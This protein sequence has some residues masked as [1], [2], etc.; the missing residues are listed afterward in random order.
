MR[1]IYFK[2]IA[3]V[4]LISIFFLSLFTHVGIELSYASYKPRFPQAETG[5]VIRITI[6]HGSTV[7][8]SQEELRRLSSVQA[9]AV[10]AMVLSFIGMGILKLSVKNIWS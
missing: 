9:I 8:V 3:V 5:R 4:S 6:N 10:S 1:N 7:Y 2:R